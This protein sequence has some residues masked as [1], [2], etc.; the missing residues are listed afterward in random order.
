MGRLGVS[1]YVRV[2]AV[3]YRGRYGVEVPTIRL[4]YS[5]SVVLQ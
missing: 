3:N 5:Y 4:G 2:E 1:L